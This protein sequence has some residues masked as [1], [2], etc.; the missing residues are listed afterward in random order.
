MSAPKQ[1]PTSLLRP[2]VQGELEEDDAA[3]VRD[4]LEGCRRCADEEG[5]VRMIVLEPDSGLDDLERA[6]LHHAV[7]AAAREP[8][9]APAGRISRRLAP[10][11][12]T[13]ALLALLAVGVLVFDLSGGGD[14]AALEGAETEE[15]SV[16][17]A[18]GE[19]GAARL[20]DTEQQ[21]T[22]E[23]G[24]ADAAEGSAASLASGGPTPYFEAAAGRMVATDLDRLGRSGET[25]RAF[26]DAY[27]PEEAPV[28]R[29][30]A[31]D[32]LT[33]NLSAEER[34]VVRACARDVLNDTTRT[35]I[36]V[37]GGY[38]SLDGEEV[39][40]LGFTWSPGTSG[41]LDRFMVWAWPRGSCE[42]PLVYRFGSIQR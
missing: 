41:A 7:I 16:A 9:P 1:H 42:S 24:A 8:H 36:P 22:D 33:Q 4:H 28:V 35:A 27:G 20:F 40:L 26:A 19:N 31:L 32:Q 17:P 30:H 25:F 12:G 6:R 38:G 10:Y 14:D 37:Y 29:S 34:A 18:T 5:A 21:G 39:L 3:T 11:L 2:Y 23:I 13:A 15:G